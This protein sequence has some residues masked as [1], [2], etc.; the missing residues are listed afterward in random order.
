MFNDESNLKRVRFNMKSFERNWD[1]YDE[2]HNRTHRSYDDMLETSVEK[3]LKT[4][5]ID[6]IS[7]SGLNF[8]KMLFDAL[9]REIKKNVTFE[10]C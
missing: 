10:G 1:I 4:T 3:I 6:V 7:E 5:M 8:M 9:I 2:K